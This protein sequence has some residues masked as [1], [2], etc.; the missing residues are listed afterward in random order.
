M[1]TIELENVN[2]NNLIPHDHATE[3]VLGRMSD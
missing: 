3:D 2:S 1:R